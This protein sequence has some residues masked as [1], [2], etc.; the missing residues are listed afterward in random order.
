MKTIFV[1][2]QND[3]VN[4]LLDNYK[5]FVDVTSTKDVMTKLVAIGLVN[6][7][8]G[9]KANCKEIISVATH[10]EINSFREE[11][12]GYLITYLESDMIA[13]KDDLKDAFEAGERWCQYTETNYPK[14]ALQFEEWFNENFK[15]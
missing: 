3:F 1:T 13:S 11:T 8:L 15:S 2:K 10:T 5:E 4:Y 12:E 6:Q 7:Q 9:N 14:S